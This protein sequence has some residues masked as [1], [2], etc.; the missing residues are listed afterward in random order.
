[1]TR[2]MLIKENN[3]PRPKKRAACSKETWVISDM[4]D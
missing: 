1:M 4:V 2:G 3:T